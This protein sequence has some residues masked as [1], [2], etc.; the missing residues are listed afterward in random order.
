MGKLFAS[1]RKGKIAESRRPLEGVKCVCAIMFQQ[2]PVAFTMMADLGAEIIKIERP[3]SGETGRGSERFLGMPI[4][5]YFETNNRGFKCL[6]LDIQKKKGLEIL[7]K[8]VKD[9]DIF[10]ENFR[11]GVAE[12]HHFAY[13]DLEK[14]N[15]GIV[16]L[17]SSAYGP[18]GPNALLPGTDGVAQAAGGIASIYGEKGSRMMT[19]Q[20]SVADETGALVNSLLSWLVCTIRK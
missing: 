9:A 18:D 16:Y 2:V 14:I 20:H 5:P 4:S 13:E 19:G 3:G 6:T 12:R 8:L 7:Y 11:P 10:A 1:I 15:P 17:S